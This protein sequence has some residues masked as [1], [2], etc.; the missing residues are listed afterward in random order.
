MSVAEVLLCAALIFGP[1][2]GYI[3]QYEQ[4][5]SS[6]DPAGFSTLVCFILIVANTMRM[7]FWLL[8]RFETTLL[9]QSVAMV[10]AQLILLE[11]IVR[12]ELQRRPTKSSAPHYDITRGVLPR[13]G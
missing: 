5:R 12:L 6:G 8:K 10:L 1:I 2:V 7:F 9:L 11:L 13:H 3:P 4:I